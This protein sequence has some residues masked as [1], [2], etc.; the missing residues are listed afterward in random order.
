[1]LN[2]WNRP[3]EIHTGLCFT[4]TEAWSRNYCKH[5]QSTCDLVASRNGCSEI[6]MWNLFVAINS[7]K[8]AKIAN[9]LPSVANLLP[10]T[11]TE[12]H[13]K[14]KFTC[15]HSESDQSLICSSGCKCL[16]TG[17]ICSG[18]WSPVDWGCCIFKLRE[19]SWLQSDSDGKKNPKNTNTMTAQP[20]WCPLFT[21]VGRAISCVVTVKEQSIR[22]RC[23]V[24]LPGKRSLFKPYLETQS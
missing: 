6:I 10:S 14:Q 19:I 12:I 11:Y 17:C 2:W 24:Q 22:G 3:V 16:E 15:S 1:M 9:L 20:Q 21:E 8:S 13:I 23:T 18:N 7:D 5:K 4:E